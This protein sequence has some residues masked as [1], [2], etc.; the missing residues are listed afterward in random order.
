MEKL[1]ERARQMQ[2]EAQAKLERLQAEGERLRQSSLES[3]EAAKEAAKQKAA[4][5]DIAKLSSAT[6][7]STISSLGIL[8]SALSRRDSADVSGEAS[9]SQ[10]SEV[11]RI[12]PN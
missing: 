3:L 4:S 9:Q 5:I 11:D 8:P 2:A 7:S 6:C 1:R 12:C 10:S